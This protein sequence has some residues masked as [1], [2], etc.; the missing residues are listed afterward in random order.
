MKT[1]MLETMKW[2]TDRLVGAL[3]AISLGL[4][5]WGLVEVVALKVRTATSERALVSVEK[6]QDSSEQ[7]IKV[8]AT[9]GSEALKIYEAKQTRISFDAETRLARVEL[10]IEKL[11]VL[12][13]RWAIMATDIA[14][15]KAEL[16]A[17]KNRRE[18]STK[19]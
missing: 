8:I 6:R 17:Q 12:T 13:E 1:E 18:N 9:G 2:L 15:I 19:P 16:Q 4:G 3:L 14:W 5:G 11:N 7:A 10:A